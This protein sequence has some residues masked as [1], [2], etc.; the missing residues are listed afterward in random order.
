MHF[1]VKWLFN[2]N[3]SVDFRLGALDHWNP[4]FISQVLWLQIFVA[5]SGAILHRLLW[6]LLFL[7]LQNEYNSISFNKLFAGS[8][9]WDNAFNHLH[10]AW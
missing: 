2:L 4:K 8:I 5:Q 6:L 1:A 7:H 9:T 3:F 10:I